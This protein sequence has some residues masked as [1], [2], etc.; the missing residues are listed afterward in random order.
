ML[1][2]RWGRFKSNGRREEDRCKDR[3]ESR[4]RAEDGTKD[5]GQEE[6]CRH[7]NT[8]AAPCCRADARNE[9]PQR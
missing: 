8:D 1:G 2:S 3:E 9:S 4:R 5:R 7:G 6:R